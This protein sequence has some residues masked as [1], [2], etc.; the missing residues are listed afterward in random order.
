MVQ[1]E[2][3]EIQELEELEKQQEQEEKEKQAKKSSGNSSAAA[4]QA[5]KNAQLEAQALAGAAAEGGNKKKLVNLIFIGDAL[6]TL[7][8]GLIVRLSRS[9]RRWE[10]YP[11]R[12]FDVLDRNA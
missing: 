7:V 12:S 4:N 5:S 3:A 2:L 11:Q 9:C 10:I 8:F 1:E 6:H